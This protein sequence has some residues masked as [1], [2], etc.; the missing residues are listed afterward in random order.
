MMSR[1]NTLRWLAALVLLSVLATG[2]VAPAVAQEEGPGP[3]PT[4]T[5]V[6]QGDVSIGEDSS[7]VIAEEPTATEEPV[8]EPADPEE[9][10]DEPSVDET[11]TSTPT[12]PSGGIGDDEDTGVST[13]EGTPTPEVSPTEEPSPT[14][15]PTEEVEAASVG[16]SVV[17]Y[18]CTSAYSGGDP[19]GNGDCTP[20]SGVGVSASTSEG[21]IGSG[22]TNGSGVASFDAPEGAN[23]LFAEDQSTLPSG[24]VPDGNGT[25]SVSASDGASTYIVNIQVSTAGRLQI[26]N[27]QCPTTGEARTEFIV[28]GPLAIQASALGCEPHAG[29]SLTVSG[30]GGTYSIVTYDDG[31]WIGTIPVGAY[32]ISN[33]HSSASLE[34]VSGSTTIVL[35]VDYVPGA[36]G[37]LSVERYD[38]AEGDEGTTIT[39]RQRSCKRILRPERSRA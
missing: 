6:A 14:P 2:L 12:D 23:V 9:E 38:C 20:A 33:A 17:I 26:A 10:T 35:V 7:A 37:T 22:S 3:S 1:S 13:G 15:T 28:V 25:A 8:T 21:P 31:N 4:A 11:V 30:P 34:V 36:K 29:A 32:T 18:T 16:V 19:A 5:E 27:G 39:D 24:Y